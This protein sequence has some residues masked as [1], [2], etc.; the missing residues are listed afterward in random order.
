[1]VFCSFLRKY[2]LFSKKLFNIKIC[3]K[4]YIHFWRKMTPSPKKWLCPPKIFSLVSPKILLFSKKLLKD[5]ILKI[6]FPI[7]KIIFILV[8]RRILF[9]KRH[10]G[11]RNGFLAFSPKI[12]IFW[13]NLVNNKI[14]DTLFVIKKFVNF[15]RKTPSFPKKLSNAPKNSFLPFSLKIQLFF[16]KMLNKEIFSI[17]FLIKKAIGDWTQL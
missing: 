13:E 1:M 17:K 9:F 14:L 6:S 15:W 5:K 11:L 7:K 8:A 4:G 12:T 2:C 10:L 16:E 3:K